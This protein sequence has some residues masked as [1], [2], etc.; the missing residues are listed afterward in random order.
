MNYQQEKIIQPVR[1]N[2][3]ASVCSSKSEA[4]FL[5]D[6]R[7]RAVIQKQQLQAMADKPTGHK[8]QAADI[9]LESGPADIGSG[10]VQ[11]KVSLDL[12]GIPAQNAVVHIRSIDRPAT[13]KVEKINGIKN[14]SDPAARHIIPQALI[15]REFKARYSGKTVA[16]LVQFFPGV[17]RDADY[18]INM[19]GA[20]QR[21]YSGENSAINKDGGGLDEPLVDARNNGKQGSSAAS[22]RNYWKGGQKE[23]LAKDTKATK[24]L[25]NISKRRDEGKAVTHQAI[26][27]ALS[28]EFD[29]PPFSSQ[30]VIKKAAEK[31]ALLT[32]AWLAGDAE[33][34][35]YYNIGRPFTWT[36]A[37]ACKSNKAIYNAAEKL[38][39]AAVAAVPAPAA[40]VPAAAPVVP[41]AA[42]APAVVPVAP[43]A[44]RANGSPARR[45][46][47]AGAADPQSPENI[48]IA[49]IRDAAERKDKNA[50]KVV[51]PP[52]ALSRR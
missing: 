10:I 27:S 35:R 48:H 20:M 6:N 4:S 21:L 51:S 36:D 37:V 38:P 30:A 5:K 2:T 46:P 52:P 34:H 24:E 7:Q 22:Y 32:N 3:L 9:Y 17:N 28:E 18:L 44:A 15:D 39:P 12:Q 45:R 16:E 26:I 47:A 14:T 13:P 50:G 42:A 23:N 31:W 49:R 29:P 33:S 11:K 41:V 43:A 19:A 25:N 8:P 40:A 1:E